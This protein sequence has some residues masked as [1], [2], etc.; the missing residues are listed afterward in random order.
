MRQRR[1]A[2]LVSRWLGWTPFCLS[3]WSS[4]TAVCAGGMRALSKADLFVFPAE[5][6]LS[7]ILLSSA[8]RPLAAASSLVRMRGFLWGGVLGTPTLVF[9]IA[10]GRPL[11][12]CLLPVLVPL[13]WQLLS[14]DSCGQ[15][16]D[17]EAHCSNSGLLA[18]PGSG[19]GA[20][21]LRS[22][23]M[24]AGSLSLRLWCSVLTTVPIVVQRS[25]CLSVQSVPNVWL[26]LWSPSSLSLV[27]SPTV[28]GLSQLQ[29]LPGGYHWLQPGVSTVKWLCAIWLLHA[30]SPWWH[31]RCRHGLFV[32]LF[33]CHPSLFAH[34]PVCVA[35]VLLVFL[36]LEFRSLS[37]W[38]FSF[39]RSH[40]GLVCHHT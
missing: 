23:W 37:S 11:S 2:V 34:C 18:R 12:F 6:G 5:R 22:L 25:G 21:L 14:K 8:P 7:G 35:D 36:S 39:T 15:W 26:Q 20:V 29:R 32:C 9:A 31:C 1:L 27:V 33:S 38:F 19:R 28:T 40:S 13:L 17:H 24:P 16:W 4:L 30:V 3:P 10:A